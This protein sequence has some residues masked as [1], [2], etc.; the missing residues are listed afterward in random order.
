MKRICTIFCISIFV[1]AI[2]SSAMATGTRVMTMGDQNMFITDDANIWHWTSTVNNYPRHMIVDHYGAYVNDPYQDDGESRVGMIM[3]FMKDGVLGVFASDAEVDWPFSPRDAESRVDLFWGKRLSS[4]DVGLH[5]EWYGD[6]DKETGESS[7]GVIGLNGGVALNQGGNMM[8]FNGFFRKISFTDESIT[9]TPLSVN[10]TQDAGSHMGIAWRWMRA[11][12]STTTI[13]P[14]IRVENWK[15][16]ETT[17][18]GQDADEFKYTS[19]DVGVGCN[20]VPL[21]GTEFLGSIGIMYEKWTDSDTSG[22]TDED[23]RLTTPYLKFGADI[24]VKPWLNFRV[25]AAKEV[26]SKDTDKDFGTAP[27]P[28]RIQTDQDWSYRIG[29][30]IML[31]DVQFDMEVDPEWLMSGPYLLSGYSDDPMFGHVSFKY[32][33]R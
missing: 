14:A 13:I 33:W 11:Q 12:N 8:E 19:V 28:D 7:H 22:T 4:A 6:S 23:T 21:A 20:T 32:D 30:G 10:R 27:D 2:A 15:I 31:G 1:L 24:Q 3:P 16:S 9:G 17:D 26:Y 29:A 25:G 18:N 5:L